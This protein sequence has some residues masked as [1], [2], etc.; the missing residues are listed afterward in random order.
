M[1]KYVRA[2]PPKDAIEKTWRRD[3]KCGAS[4]MTTTG[5]HLWNAAERLAGDPWQRCSIM[6]CPAEA[7]WGMGCDFDES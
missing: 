3:I 1:A 4:A 7:S 5:G 6:P 2:E